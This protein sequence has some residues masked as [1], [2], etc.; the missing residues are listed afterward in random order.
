MYINMQQQRWHFACMIAWQAWT[1]IA[2]CI[3]ANSVSSLLFLIFR[4]N[5]YIYIGFYPLNIAL[6]FSKKFRFHDLGGPRNC[7]TRPR[8]EMW[9]PYYIKCKKVENKVFCLGV[10]IHIQETLNF[11]SLQVTCTATPNDQPFL[12]KMSHFAV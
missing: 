8:W 12:A 4:P 6:V 3:Q 9:I 5:E 7:K 1:S 10:K 11:R 2:V